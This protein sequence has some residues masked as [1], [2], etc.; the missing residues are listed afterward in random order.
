MMPKESAST[1]AAKPAAAPPDSSSPFFRR[2]PKQAR[3]RQLVERILSATVA[4]LE[5]EGLP[6]LSTNRIAAEAGVDIASLYQYFS[7]KEAILYGLAERWVNKVQAVYASYETRL[8]SGIGLIPLLRDIYRELEAMPENDWG[9][10]Q[11]AAL[12]ETVPELRQIE[13]D[14]EVAT[15]VFWMKVLRSYGV[16][17]DDDR[18]AAFVRLRYVQADAAFMLAG[19]LPEAQAVHIRRWQRRQTVTM[20]RLCFPKSNHSPGLAD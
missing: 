17:W 12:M 6:A 3:S 11:L 5:R 10:R 1:P 14:H 4:L 16:D 8:G 18:L 13:D 15:T 20:L 2:T 9:Y 19:R 7:S